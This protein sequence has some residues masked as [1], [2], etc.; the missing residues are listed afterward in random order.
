VTFTVELE[1]ITKDGWLVQS[2]VV[3][4]VPV[5]CIV[6]NPLV[7]ILWVSVRVVLKG[8]VQV[9]VMIER[10]PFIVIT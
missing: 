3:H 4:A 9:H 2:R 8:I 6:P 7:V 10:G 1:S 5:T